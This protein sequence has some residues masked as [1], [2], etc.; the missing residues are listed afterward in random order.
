MSLWVSLGGRS[1]F[2]SATVAWRVA[3]GHFFREFLQGYKVVISK[4]NPAPK[5]PDDGYMFRITDRNR[6]YA[7]IS[8][9]DHYN[10]GDFSGYLQP[11]KTCYFSITAVYSDVKVAGNAVVMDST[12]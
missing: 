8:S 4:N 5:Y 9:S 3:E 12:L 7:I 10:G 11:G 6:N 1:L 2:R